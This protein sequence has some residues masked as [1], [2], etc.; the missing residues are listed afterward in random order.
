MFGVQRTKYVT[1][2]YEVSNTP[3]LSLTTTQSVSWRTYRVN[4]AY[5]VDPSLGNTSMPGYNQWMGTDRFYQRWSPV[6][7]KIQTT[8][9]NSTVGPL[10]V[11]MYINPRTSGNYG[12]WTAFI[13]S[14]SN[15]GAK[16][17]LL[18]NGSGGHE[19][20][21][22]SLQGFPQKIHYLG[23]APGKTPFQNTQSWA[24]NTGPTGEDNLFC[25]LWIGTADGAAAGSTK[26]VATKT[27]IWMR[28]KMYDPVEHVNA[29]I[30]D[31]EIED[32][33]HAAGGVE[34]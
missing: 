8:F 5:D 29:Q 22:L 25:Y 1:F 13:D 2:R 18:G 10:Y 9:V 33:G 11:G 15:P 31:T 4:N 23:E 20:C 19:K 12:T 26:V 16:K 27:T 17:V 7:F 30:A 34:A 32:D 6:W 21:T 14:T 3:T 28:I 24:Y